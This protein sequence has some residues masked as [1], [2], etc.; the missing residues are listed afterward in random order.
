M[1]A[2]YNLTDTQIRHIAIICFREQGSN[3]A[4]VRACA[5]H[6]C[7]YY[8]KWQSKKYSNP[9]DCTLKSGW[10]WSEKKNL[11][12]IKNHP[13]V[14]NSVV[15]IVS[16]VFRNGKRNIPTYCDEY[17]CLSDVRKATN[18]GRSFPPQDRSQY[19]KDVTRIENVYGSVY[20]FYCFPD[21]AKGYTDAFGYI[22]KPVSETK[23]GVPQPTASTVS[24]SHAQIEYGDC[25]Q[26]VAD[27]QALLNK[28]G[29]GL[30]VDGV[31]GLKTWY[32]VRDFQSK[33]GLL[34]D[35]VVGPKTWAKL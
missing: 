32:A 12:W 17:D 7:N 20:T 28:C 29:Y 9:Y 30:A 16:D 5:S 6:M 23:L 34:V 4:G 21:G 13:N 2:K 31:F 35:G 25:G 11:D 18:N 8:E 3:D 22:S 26:D 1:S 14:P 15:A 10:Y 19:I 24:T 33:H 27:C